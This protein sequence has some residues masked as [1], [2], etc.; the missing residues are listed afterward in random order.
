VI[1][2]RVTPAQASALE[3][4]VLDPIH[5]EAAEFFEEPE[6]VFPGALAGRWLEIPR[7]RRDDACRIL[8]EAANSA[9]EDGCGAVA[10]TN[11]SYHV[12]RAP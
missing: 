4:Y 9:D 10:L 7:D 2:L 11:L 8:I 12:R 6:D 1:R 3:I 5:A